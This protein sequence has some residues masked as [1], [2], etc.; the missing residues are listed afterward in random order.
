MNYMDESPADDGKIAFPQPTG[1]V[2]ELCQNVTF[3]ARSVSMPQFE[4][5]L[6]LRKKTLWATW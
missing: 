4:L 6:E 2:R 1:N 3:H 5:N